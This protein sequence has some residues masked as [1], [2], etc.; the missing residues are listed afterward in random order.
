MYGMRVCVFVEKIRFNK[1][2]IDWLIHFVLTNNCVAKY[3]SRKFCKFNYNEVFN[4]YSNV[5][6]NYLFFHN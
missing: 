3:L 5:Y 2:N 6:W 1:L 4:D